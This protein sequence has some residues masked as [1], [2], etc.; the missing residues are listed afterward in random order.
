M[1][2]VT[3]GTGLLGSHLL[4]HLTRNNQ[5]VRA[6]YRNDSA[7]ARVKEVFQKYD[8][9]Q[10]STYFSQIDWVQADLL[11]LLSLEDAFQGISHVYHCAGMVSFEKKYFSQLIKINREGT[12]N[13]VNMCLKFN[14]VKLCH[15]SSTAALGGQNEEQ[16]N[17]KTN[18]K[19]TPHTS[20]YAFSKYAAE[21]EVWRGI[22]E[23]LTAVIINPS[24]IF[25]SGS[26]DKGSLSIFR[27]VDNGLRF[28]TGGAN[29]FVDARDLA[30]IMIQLMESRIQN[31]RFV[32]VGENASFYS[33]LSKIANKLNKRP[34]N[35]FAPDWLMGFAWRLSWVTAVIH[36][37]R[38]TITKA[39]AHAST[40]KLYY[41]NS[42]ILNAIE[43]SFR[44]LDE[45]IE[46]AI[47]TKI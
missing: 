39:S 12:A 46:N 8:C 29:G 4:F 21:K 44:N 16:I 23:G 18:W 24:I 35:V 2:L 26:W 45:M 47:N 25:G 38:P 22:E 15:V 6:L 43:F 33:L 9:K 13:I 34:P 3:G 40:Y 20:A 31:E 10:F 41:D 28:Y 11:D 5:Q 14:V 17:E 19:Q 27:T 30:T 1:I 32:C 42:K 36:R 37:R 7:V